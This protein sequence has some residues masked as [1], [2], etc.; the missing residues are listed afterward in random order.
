MSIAVRRKI[1]SRHFRRH[2]TGIALQ[3]LVSGLLR[4][5]HVPPIHRNDDPAAI[6]IVPMSIVVFA[7][8]D[9][10]NRMPFRAFAL[11]MI[12]LVAIAVGY[13]LFVDWITPPGVVDPFARD[14][15]DRR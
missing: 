3:R 5:L 15:S 4:V 1:A 7:N 6:V 10:A 11:M 14:R 2:C 12:G 8:L 9:A 13:S